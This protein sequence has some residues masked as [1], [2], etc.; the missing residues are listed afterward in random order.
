MAYIDA[1]GSDPELDSSIDH[2]HRSRGHAAIPAIP[3]RRHG[4]RDPGPTVGH[5]LSHGI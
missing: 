5:W 3:D 4:R 1:S 2:L